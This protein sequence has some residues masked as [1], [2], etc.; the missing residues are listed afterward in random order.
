M[1]A[2]DTG[3]VKI[4]QGDEQLLMDA[5][6]RVGPISVAMDA[7]MNDFRVCCLKWYFLPVQDKF[8]KTNGN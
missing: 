3:Y 2:T 6:Y 8:D 5:V 4:P 1:G 7:S